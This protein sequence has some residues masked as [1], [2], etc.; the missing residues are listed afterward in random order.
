MSWFIKDVLDWIH[1]CTP[2]HYGT[3]R[4]GVLRVT[5]P[6]AYTFAIC[7][8]LTHHSHRFIDAEK[9]GLIYSCIDNHTHVF[10]DHYS[11][12]TLPVVL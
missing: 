8:L 3:G 4:L 10:G 12:Q 6:Y 7:R 9:C 1:H 5:G 11:Q 2:E